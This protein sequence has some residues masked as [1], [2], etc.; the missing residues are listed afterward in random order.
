M[1]LDEGI[2]KFIGRIYESVYDADAWRS[3][4]LDMLELTNSRLSFISVVD[5]QNQVYSRTEFY[6]L[7]SSSAEVGLQ[8]YADTMYQFDPSLAWASQHP[9]AGVC[10]TADLMPHDEF[11]RLPYSKWQADRLGTEHWCVFY[12]KPVD[13]LSFGL[14]LHPPR[15]DGPACGE[16][17]KLH[18]L[19][20]DHLKRALRLAARPPDLADTSE[21]IFVLSNSGEVLA[22]S[23]RA[24]RL[25]RERDGLIMEGRRLIGRSRGVTTILEDALRSAVQS[26]SV[27]SSGRGVRLRRANGPDWLALVSPTPRNLDHLP[28]QS[29][30]AVL[31]IIESDSEVTL[32]R[33][34][35]EL[36][37]LSPR[38]VDVAQALLRGHTLESLCMFLGISRNTGKV[39]LHSLFEKTGTNRQSELVHLL[40]ILVRH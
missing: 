31:R 37:D 17:V 27:G 4:M 39:H 11:S 2:S 12:T 15:H 38:E 7:D 9:D 10:Q 24:E 23:P 36:F 34:H 13:G 22:M 5:V 40:S 20:F 3:L 28:V 25:V 16:A 35:A 8:E 33:G 30:A 6:G 26:F 29:P 32:T 14:A 21:S 1:S 19:F 18:G